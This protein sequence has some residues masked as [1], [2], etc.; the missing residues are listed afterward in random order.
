MCIFPH[1]LITKYTY[2]C[3]SHN[4]LTLKSKLYSFD[5]VQLIRT[6][7][8][9]KM[10]KQVFCIVF[11]LLALTAHAE[12][13]V[14]NSS[15]KR[16]LDSAT[17]ARRTPQPKKGFNLAPFPEFRVDPVVGVYVGVNATL[18]DY[19]E[20]TR[21]PDYNKLLNL[22]AAWGTKGKTNVSLRYKHFGKRVLFINVGH[23]VANLH[24]F[25]GFNGYQTV[26]N[27]NFEMSESAQYI[28]QAFY[29]YKRKRSQLDFYVQDNFKGTSLNWQLGA[30]VSYYDVNRVDFESIN[31]NTI[32]ED[33]IVDASTLYDRYIEWGIIEQDERRGGWA[34]SFRAG[35]LYDSRDRLTNP[36]KGLWAQATIRYTPSFLGNK[37]EGMQVGIKH[38]QFVTLVPDRISFAYRLRYDGT[39]GNLAF[40]QR[41]VLADGVEGYGGAIGMVGEGFGTIWG[42]RQNRVVGK[43]MAL[44]NFEVRAKLFHLRLFKQNWHT[45]LVPIY[46]TGLILEPYKMDLS[47]VS[48]TDRQAFFTNNYKGWYHAVGLGGKLVMNDNIVIGLDWSAALNSQAGD[49]AFYVGFGYTF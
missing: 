39:F 13:S 8:S 37:K 31:K 10:I 22:N 48:A 7:G 23:S 43:Q 45:A 9:R 40:Y 17:I 15:T 32:G 30:I 44:G 18:F 33:I 42:V 2:F 12:S 46:H 25:Y 19:G 16:K 28:T 34:N 5:Y 21:Y 3:A 26:Y 6:M 49:H 4:L 1:V 29:K 20:G 14:E 38:H 24:P 35:F 27:K 11:A 47:N 36:M 41:Q